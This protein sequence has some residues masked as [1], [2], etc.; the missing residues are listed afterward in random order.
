MFILESL[1]IKIRSLFF[2]AP[3]AAL[4]A[5]SAFF[6]VS[7]NQD[8]FSYGVNI[9]S[10]AAITFLLIVIYSAFH[11]NIRNSLLSTSFALAFFVF[12]YSDP[13]KPF[14]YTEENFWRIVLVALTLS[15]LA[16]TI[17]KF[18]HN[19]S[20]GVEEERKKRQKAE[21]RAE[22]L[23]K[24]G[25]RKEEIISMASHELKAPLTSIQLTAHALQK[26]MERQTT[27]HEVKPYVTKLDRQVS[28]LNRLITNMFDLSK[29]ATGKFVLH[30]ELFSIDEL[31]QDL[32]TDIQATT[33][34]HQIISKGHA[35]R[36][37]NADK[38][39]ISQ[40]ITNLVVNA[41]RYS[42]NADK[43]IITVKE[44]KQNI[45]LSIKDFGIGIAKEHQ[46]KIFDQFYQVN[47]GQRR[48]GGLGIGLYISSRIIQ[49]H[50]GTISVLSDEGKGST[51]SVTLPH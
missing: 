3:F 11:E 23:K 31:L 9:R 17:H 8:S 26:R 13:G 43:I 30:K 48:R 7:G 5:M 28:N 15:G 45:S 27:A 36:K 40:V 41:I 4:I 32:I 37:I 18:R 16:Y 12:I 10:I 46:K 51:F 19:I 22:K 24:T 6:F 47:G 38:G 33:T 42:P 49:Q 50:G 20:Y 44:T 14:H 25:A 29:I 34:T 1:L 2:T 35:K 21:V 39:F